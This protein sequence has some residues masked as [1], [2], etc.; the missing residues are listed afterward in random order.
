L[1][2]LLKYGRW[3]SIGTR[4]ANI[5]PPVGRR[6]SPSPWRSS[7]TE[8]KFPCLQVE[9]VDIFVNKMSRK[10]SEE[11]GARDEV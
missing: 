5:E 10:I 8:F 9:P 4:L 6:R 3:V 7:W 1:T 11:C 2:R